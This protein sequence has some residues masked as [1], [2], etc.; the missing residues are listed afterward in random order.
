MNSP[1]LFVSGILLSGVGF[2][3]FFTGM[4]LFYATDPNCEVECRPLTA[5]ESDQRDAGLGL[6]LG[7]GALFALGLPMLLIGG[8]QVPDKPAWAQKA[9]VLLVGGRSAALRW[10][11]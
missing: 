8:K 9:P 6:L 5:G 2:V 4:G 7:G 1:T 11:F 3:G 10:S